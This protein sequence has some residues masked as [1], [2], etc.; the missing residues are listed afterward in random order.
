MERLTGFEPAPPGWGPRLLPLQQS[1][2]ER[3]AEI[4]PAI[5]ERRSDV[6]PQHFARGTLRGGSG[7]SR[8]LTYRVRAGDARH[9]AT[10]PLAPPSGIEPEPSALQAD[11]QTTY[12]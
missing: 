11:A 2:A 7:G 1:R 8:T 3:T 4:E 10:D 12:A 9:Y 5:S 6:S